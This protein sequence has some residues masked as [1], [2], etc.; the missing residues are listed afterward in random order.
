MTSLTA[1]EKPQRSLTSLFPPELRRFFIGFA[2]SNI[3]LN[4]RNLLLEEMSRKPGFGGIHGGEMV[5]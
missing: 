2:L 3:S 1:M 5:T 4:A